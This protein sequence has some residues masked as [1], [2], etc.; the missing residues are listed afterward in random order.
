MSIYCRYGLV[1]EQKKGAYKYFVDLGDK[2]EVATV[3]TSYVDEVRT[4]FVP[5]T[6]PHSTEN[7][8]QDRQ[9][10]VDKTKIVYGADLGTSADGDEDN[11]ESTGTFGVRVVKAST[12]VS[13]FPHNNYSLTWIPSCSRFIPPKKSVL[14][15]LW[16]LNLVTA[17]SHPTRLL[18]YVPCL[19]TLGIKL[20]GFKDRGELRFEDN[21]KHSQFIYPDEMVRQDS[22]I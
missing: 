11:E 2:M 7:I 1:T 10:D 8:C 6:S 13:Y 14:F 22:G 5:L 20:L 19:I 15:V 16:V 18:S 3:R 12:R 9:A 4:N 21:I 17:F